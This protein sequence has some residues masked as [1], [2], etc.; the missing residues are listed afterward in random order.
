MRTHRNS[1][2]DVKAD[3]VGEEVVQRRA[4]RGR[5]PKDAPPPE[6]CVE[7][8]VEVGFEFNRA[9]AEVL[10]AEYDIGV[11]VTNIP[12]ATED[13]DNVRHGAT[14]ATVLRLYLDQYK[15]EH[16]YRLMKSGM[17]VD[18]VYVRTPKRADALLFVVA[19]STLISSI[20][21]ALLRRSGACPYPTVKRAAEEIQHVSFVFHR[22][23]GDITVVGPE[24]SADRVFAYIDG[25]GLDPSVLFEK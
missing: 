22:S 10:A 2:Y 25:I 21:D 19:I 14:T 5:P 13:R 12:F 1:A 24:G 16:T 17:G 9:R 3:I 15:V 7:W 4:S 6:T 11:I 23:T 18:S 8:R 20:I